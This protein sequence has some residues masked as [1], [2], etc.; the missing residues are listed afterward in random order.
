MPGR[1]RL[2]QAM[3]AVTAA[4]LFELSENK[5]LAL[6]GLMLGFALMMFHDTALG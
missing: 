5:P 1:W 3:V 6:I 4:E 2:R